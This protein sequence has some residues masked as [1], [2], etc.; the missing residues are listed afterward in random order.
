MPTPAE[1]S[2]IET[3]CSHLLKQKDSVP[4]IINLGAGKSRRIEKFLINKECK[5]ICDR[6]DIID[7][8]IDG[9]FVGKCYISSIECMPEIPSNRYAAGFSNYVLE[10]ILDLNGAA[11]EIYQILKSGGISFN[12][13]KSRSSGILVIKTNTCGISQLAKIFFKR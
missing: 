11:N 2:L 8:Q 10:H 5:F 7:F 13:S 9:E 1:K 4:K 6:V 12:Y 3:M